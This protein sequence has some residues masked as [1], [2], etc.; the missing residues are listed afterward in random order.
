MHV[1][2]CGVPRY[3]QSVDVLRVNNTPR[4]TNGLDPSGHFIASQRVM[5]RKS[6]HNEVR[7]LVTYRLATFDGASFFTECRIQFEGTAMSTMVC[8]HEHLMSRVVVTCAC[9]TAVVGVLVLVGWAGD[10]TVLKSV[11][12]GLPTMKVNTAISLVLSALSLLM[13]GSHVPPSP[14]RQVVGLVSAFLVLVIIALTLAQYA[15]SIDFGIDQFLFRDS[16]G[17]VPRP[18]P[19]RMAPV[20]AFVLASGLRPYSGSSNRA[21]GLSALAAQSVPEQRSKYYYPL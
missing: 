19:G 4:A 11:L 10:I 5:Q 6:L 17:S 9:V 18:F 8:C 3:Q 14:R 12:S 1:V 13:G 21:M 7:I 15:F 20:T 2:Y 16:T